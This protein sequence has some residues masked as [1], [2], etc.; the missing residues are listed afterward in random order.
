MPSICF[1]QVLTGLSFSTVGYILSIISNQGGYAVGI[2]MIL[3]Y[4]MYGLVENLPA[5]SFDYCYVDACS[6]DK[7]ICLSCFI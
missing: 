3:L 4:L 1:E 5:K 2:K 6:A 7:N